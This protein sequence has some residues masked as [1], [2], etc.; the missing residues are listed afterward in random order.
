MQE[1]N[2]N[3]IANAIARDLL[4]NN[5]LDENN[6]SHDTNTLLDCVEKI[7]LEHL[8]DYSLLSGTVF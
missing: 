7:I 3:N 8:K 2:R 4:D 1:N 6:F 5:I